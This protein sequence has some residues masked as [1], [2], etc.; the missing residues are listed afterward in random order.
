MIK[1]EDLLPRTTAKYGI[2]YESIIMDDYHKTYMC[3]YEHRIYDSHKRM[4]VTKDIRELLKEFHID[5]IFNYHPSLNPC[6]GDGNKYKRLEFASEPFT[7]DELKPSVM[8]ENLEKLIEA[9]HDWTDKEFYLPDHGSI[10]CFNYHEKEVETSPS[11]GTHMTVSFPLTIHD[12]PV[13]WKTFIWL[14]TGLLTMYEPIYIALNGA[15]SQITKGSERQRVSGSVNVGSAYVY[16]V[17]TLES[18]RYELFINSPTRGNYTVPDYPNYTYWNSKEIKYKESGPWRENVKCDI[19]NSYSS[20]ADVFRLHNN[21]DIYENRNTLIDKKFHKNYEGIESIN[22]VTS[23]LIEFRFFDNEPANHLLN[24]F[25]LLIRI[26]D[27]AYD[28]SLFMEEAIGIDDLYNFLKSQIDNKLNI[29][30]LVNRKAWHDAVNESMINGLDMIF[31]KEFID[32]CYEA[33]KPTQFMHILEN[34]ELKE[35]TAIDLHDLFI[36]EINTASHH[37]SEYFRTDNPTNT[38]S[39]KHQIKKY[40]ESLALAKK[41]MH[42]YLAEEERKAEEERIIKAKLEE[43]RNIKITVILDE[44]LLKLQQTNIALYGDIVNYIN[45]P[46]F[47]DAI[48]HRIYYHDF[49]VQDFI[50]NAE[51]II[52]LNLISTF[53]EIP[54]DKIIKWF[55]ESLIPDLR[56]KEPNL[57]ER[58]D[59]LELQEN[60]RQLQR[61]RERI[62]YERSQPISRPS[63]I[64]SEG[65][66]RNIIYNTISR[67]SSSMD[68]N[69]HNII[70]QTISYSKL[71]DILYH[72]IYT[73]QQSFG[74]ISDLS[75]L[76]IKD[77][78]FEN[79]S[80]TQEGLEIIEKWFKQILI[81]QLRELLIPPSSE[82]SRTEYPEEQRQNEISRI[83]DTIELNINNLENPEMKE[84]IL[85][86]QTH[87]FAEELHNFIYILKY[88]T[89]EIRQHL[90]LLIEKGFYNMETDNLVDDPEVISLLKTWISDYLMDDLVRAG[91]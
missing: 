7:P 13:R 60:V 2:E 14:F 79:I 22:G 38:Y 1:K 39:K 34:P 16:D 44:N 65:E 28:Q 54:K 33:F 25:N 24:K 80:Y 57:K 8:F 62:Q 78:I 88:N 6:K 61:E 74:E 47:V 10:A 72:R 19:G 68:S 49:E 15:P 86:Y 32:A 83:K 52:E 64:Q 90:D 20:R 75:N 12:N 5:H 55:K 73:V 11:G 29:R 87:I 70:I 84:I 40:E 3:L 56:E 58:E 69:S 77:S 82:I 41:Q 37:F 35:I 48:S 43:D 23:N 67:T 89:I 71:A 26:A 66:L 21:D 51:S 4:Y 63:T 91:L 17:F 36:D 31:N 50:I 27:Y 81:P 85:K 30:P 42:T 53:D 18:E 46:K 76:I 45:K 9:F 59:N